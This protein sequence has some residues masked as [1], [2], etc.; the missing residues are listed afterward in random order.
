M[1]IKYTLIFFGIITIIF[2]I[3]NSVYE[4][5]IYS[6]IWSFAWGGIII[7]FALD[8]KLQKKFWEF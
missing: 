1:I 6:N 4:N 2:S 3:I 8:A 5:S 7:W